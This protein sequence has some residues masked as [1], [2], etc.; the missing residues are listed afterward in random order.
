MQVFKTYFRIIKKNM[1]QISIYIGVF[2]TLAILFSFSSPSKDLDNFMQA[3]TRVAFINEDEHSPLIDGLRDYLKDYSVYVSLENDTQKLQDALFFRDVEYIVKIPKGFTADIMEGKDAKIGKITVS[4]STNGIYTDMLVNKYLSTVKMY[5]TYYNNITQAELA[6]KAADD[7]KVATHVQIKRD[8][9]Q[10]SKTGDN[11]I[12]FFNYLA[13]AITSILLLGVTSIMMVFNNKNI[14]R[15][16]L[17]SPIKNSSLNMQIILGNI[18]YAAACWGLMMVCNFLLFRD[19]MFTLNGLYFCINSL[20][21]TVMALC[22]A[23][24]AGI[25]VK[26]S[27]AQSSVTNVLGLGLSFISGVFVPQEF[28]SKAVLDIAKFTPA[29]WYVKANNEISNLTNFNIENLTP[30]FQYMLIELCFGAALLSVALVLTKRKQMNG[31]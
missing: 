14:R 16:T 26:S 31:S 11:A 2:L 3:K 24:F 8:E 18:I 12:Y 23:F 25:F 7:L 1:G 6:E 10:N 5:L 29:Y 22:L 27:N 17:C 20:V 9:N 21:F 13:Y 28:L 30:I 4:E 19:D 15:R